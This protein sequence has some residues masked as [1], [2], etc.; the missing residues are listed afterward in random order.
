MILFPNAKINIGL[1]ITEKRTDG[2]HNIETIFYPVNIYDILEFV[3][4]KDN[5][6][7]EF[8]NTGIKIN[9]PD[10]NNLVLRAYN[11]LKKDF[12]IP[13]L[14]IHLHKLIPFGAGTGG[15]SADAS[16][17]MIALNVKFNLNI[18]EKKLEEYASEI[19]S[20]C[21]FF[22]KNKPVYAYGK[23]NKFRDINLS[24]KKYFLLLVKPKISVATKD[25]YKEVLPQ[26]P[27]TNLMQLIKQPIRMW[28][29]TIKNDFEEIIFKKY[30]EIEEIKNKLYSA[31][32]IFA[33]M[34][35]SGASVFGIF[36]EIPDN[37]KLFD[38][39]SNFIITLK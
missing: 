7:I 31:G 38:K 3:E 1:N 15:G 37:L 27:E 33:L 39:Y 2:F 35:G 26:K 4:N 10:K 8:T 14:K 23:G 21:A 5:N 32:A 25:A 22:I 20:D 12:D 29:N 19:G 34:S 17:M 18:S 11:L 9:I 16:F 13:V 24:L 36:K 28:K 6:K 30:P